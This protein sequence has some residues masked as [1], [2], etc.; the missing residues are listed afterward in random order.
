MKRASGS[1]WTAKREITGTLEIKC[2]LRWTYVRGF[3]RGDGVMDRL[4]VADLLTV[5]VRTAAIQAS[6]A[7]TALNF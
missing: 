4:D 6:I 5:E 7:F 3:G 2:G 1:S